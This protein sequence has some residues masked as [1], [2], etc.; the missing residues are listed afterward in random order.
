MAIQMSTKYAT[1]D[2]KDLARIRIRKM[3]MSEM[4][5]EEVVAM[6]ERRAVQANM[7]RKVGGKYRQSTI[8]CY[9]YM[10]R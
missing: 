7:R 5:D 9:V 10:S 2:E 8:P 6:N 4:T 1:L 3:V